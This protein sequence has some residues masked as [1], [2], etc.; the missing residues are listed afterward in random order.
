MDKLAGF[1]LGL[2]LASVVPGLGF[3]CLL[4][5]AYIFVVQP[6]LQGDV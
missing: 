6:V 5:L 3:A 2:Y 1:A 4:A